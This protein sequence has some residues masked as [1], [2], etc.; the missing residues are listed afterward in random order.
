MADVSRAAATLGVNYPLIHK[1]ILAEILKSEQVIPHAPH[2]TRAVDLESEQVVAALKRKAR[3]C[4]VNSENQ[5]SIFC[6]I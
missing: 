1:P 2:Q 6:N 3:P 4:Q 5:T